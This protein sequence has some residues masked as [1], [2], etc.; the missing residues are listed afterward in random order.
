MLRALIRDFRLAPVTFSLLAASVALFFAVEIHKSRSDDSL[1]GHPAFGAIVQLQLASRSETEVHGPFDLWDGPWWRWLK[2]PLSA[3]HHVNLLHLACNASSIWFFGPLVEHR[4]GRV[5]LLLFW[6]FAATVPFV[7][8]YFLMHSPIGLSG[9]A[10][11]LFGWCLWER[12]FDSSIAYRVH[13]GVIR[14]TWFFLFGCIVATTAGLIQIANLAHF[15]GV[16]Y[17]WLTARASRSR[18]GRWALMAGHLVLPLAIWGVMHPFWN[19]H[20]FVFM[21]RQTTS[22]ARDLSAGVPFLQKA[23]ALDPSL[24]R[25]WESLAQERTLQGDVVNA[26]KFASEGVFH[27]RSDDRLERLARILWPSIPESERSNA[28]D[29]FDKRFGNDAPFWAERLL[30]AKSDGK[31]STSPNNEDR[32]VFQ[33][34]DDAARRRGRRTRKPELNPDGSDSASEGRTL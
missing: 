7:G 19:S 22:K 9:V 15:A 3:F 25:A 11:A 26:W 30:V 1:A 16:G 24:P 6:F 12:H 4:L 2:I 34:M 29:W 18:P 20:Y 21:A 10:C 13:D 33:E 27:N 23:L 5:R 8:E 28:R 32:D 31:A 17:G 14:S